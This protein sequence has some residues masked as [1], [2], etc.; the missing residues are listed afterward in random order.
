M[1]LTT[2]VRLLLQR[3]SAGTDPFTRT[4]MDTAFANIEANVALDNQGLL[5]A[6]PAAAVANRGMYYAATDANDLFRSD[7]T[8]WHFI[9]E[10]ISTDIRP[11]LTDAFLFGVQP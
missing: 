8:Q 3:W 4:Q 9:A 6:R 10:L 11:D 5:S 1:A 2:T 7:G